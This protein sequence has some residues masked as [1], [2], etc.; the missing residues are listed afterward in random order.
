[1]FVSYSNT[2]PFTEM[3]G[4]G[5]KALVNKGFFLCRERIEDAV[6]MMTEKFQRSHIPKA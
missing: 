5:K 6:L 4:T 1:V 2:K 3:R